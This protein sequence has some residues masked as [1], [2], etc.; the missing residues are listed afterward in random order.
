MGDDSLTLQ[1]SAD[2]RIQITFNGTQYINLA[3][4]NQIDTVTIPNVTAG[5]YILNMRVMNDTSANGDNG[6][7]GNP[8]GGAWKLTYS[9]GEVIR[10][11]A[12]LS[13]SGSSNL[14]WHTRMASGYRYTTVPQG[15]ESQ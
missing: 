15:N 11:S 1:A 12:D 4:L 3:T 2:N 14:Y 13:Q 10:T 9:N 6:W 8:G 7:S 5:N